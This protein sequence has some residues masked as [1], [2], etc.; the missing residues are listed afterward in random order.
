MNATK[1]PKSPSKSGASK[2]TA[3][4]HTLSASDPHAWI[5]GEGLATTADLPL[6][7][8]LIDEVIGQ[9]DAVEVAKKAARQRRHLLLLGDPG[10]GKSMI[11]KAMAQIL[12]PAHLDDVLVYPNPKDQNLPVIE[13]HEGGKGRA[14]FQEINDKAIRK[15]R[16]FRV[17]EITLAL[18]L[19]GGSILAFFFLGGGTSGLIL[20]ALCIMVALFFLFVSRQIAGKP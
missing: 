2:P 10:T 15:G 4:G 1:R 17:F 3:N 5:Q 9:E 13:V 20:M 18:G 7:E 11:A 14:A 12:P 8:L 6:P 19:I 16:F